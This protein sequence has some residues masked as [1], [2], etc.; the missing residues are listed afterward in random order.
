[1]S[2]SVDVAA[3][4][5]IRITITDTRLH[6]LDAVIVDSPFY[7]LLMLILHNNRLPFYLTKPFSLF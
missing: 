1:V 3:I 2:A 7:Q 4:T 5:T 6:V